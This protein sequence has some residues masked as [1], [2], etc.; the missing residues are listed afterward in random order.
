MFGPLVLMMLA[1]CTP[2]SKQN[3]VLPPTPVS[4]TTAKLASAVYYDQYQATVVAI[5]TVEL[6]SEVSGFIT[7][8]FF[9]DGDGI[10]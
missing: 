1:S 2:Q 9:K 7:G 8:I 5:N 4:V 10:E 6:R 3:T